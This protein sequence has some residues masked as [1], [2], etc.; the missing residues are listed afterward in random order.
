MFVMPRPETGR[1]A[2]R[3]LTAAVV[4]LASGLAAVSC[5]GDRARNTTPQVVEI[6]V[7]AGTQDKLDRGE[8][9]DV[10]PAELHFRIGDILRIRNNDRAEQFVGPYLVQP[11]QQFELEF[12]ATGR[13]GGLCNLS[14]GQT[15]LIVITE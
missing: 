6:V 8:I 13:Y 9:V 3:A 10:M 11:G 5:G 15:Y 2:G 12:G 1:R 14:G 7:P 4:I